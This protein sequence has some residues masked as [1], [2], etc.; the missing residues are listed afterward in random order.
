MVF[1]KSYAKTTDKSIYPKWIE[2]FLT[3]EEEKTAEI[4]CR[5]KN[6]LVMKECLED[7]ALIVK[8]KKLFET[9]SHIVNIANYLFDKRASH[10]VFF[11]EKKTK[12][13]FDE[14]NS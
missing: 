14:I 9:Q 10:E 1:S 12:E 5:E 7:A 13:K 4:E 2:I 3:D 11:K 6:I 8:E